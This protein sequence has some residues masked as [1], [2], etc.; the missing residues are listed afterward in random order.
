MDRTLGRAPR[1]GQVLLRDECREA[2]RLSRTDQ[3]GNSVSVDLRDDDLPDLVFGGI[4]P[5]RFHPC[6][7]LPVV[8]GRRRVVDRVGL[9]AMKQEEVEQRREALLP[10]R[11]GEGVLVPDREH[12]PVPPVPHRREDDVR[13][14]LSVAVGHLQLEQ[15]GGRRMGCGRTLRVPDTA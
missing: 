6:R 10:Q 1:R 14:L 5:H 7:L 2:E 9:V 11:F 4:E 13:E 15:M 3:G 12:H 8:R